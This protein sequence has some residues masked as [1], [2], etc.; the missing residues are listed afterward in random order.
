M[1]IPILENIAEAKRATVSPTRKNAA[2]LGR[3]G[4]PS[5][6]PIGGATATNPG[7]PG[8]A[9]VVDRQSFM[10][11]LIEAYLTCPPASACID[12]IARTCTAGG[13]ECAP[14]ARSTPGEK[15]PEPPPEVLEVE[16]LLHYVNPYDDIRQLMRAVITDLLIFGD[17]FTEVV[18]L[19]GKPVALYPLD[20]V[21]IAILADEH[22]VISGYQQTMQTGK[23]VTFKPWEVVHVKYDTPGSGLYGVSPLQKSILSITTWLFTAALIKE[24]MRRGDPL[25]AHVDWPIALPEAE[26]KRLQQQYAIRNIGAR[27]IGNLFETK[28]GALVKELGINQLDSWHLSLQQR[29]DEI[30]TGL[31]V[32][33]SI[34]SVIEAG[35]LGGGTGSSQHRSFQ[36][37]TCGPISEMVLEKF[38]F[39]LL[40]QAYDVKDW[41]LQF[42]LVDWRDD[43]VIEQIADLRVRSGRWTLNKSREVVGEPPVPG[44]DD[45]IIVMRQDM[46]QWSD[47]K[48]L[49]SANVDA[50]KAKAVPQ[51][52]PTTQP[53]T[54]PSSPAESVREAWAQYEERRKR[55]REELSV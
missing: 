9:G 37:N 38:S 30:L 11:S 50:I 25:R 46:A 18:Y 33:P 17:S 54:P 2:V 28:G 53:S 55:L 6:I 22:G 26:M 19:M 29:R 45:A 43:M 52:S 13:V 10:Q 42:G 49:S 47:L 5:G 40:Y 35:N 23:T 8:G 20:P 7:Q 27:N 16:E 41:H 51:G 34:V 21:T 14:N 15:P 3:R 24:T 1:G 48:E 44:G 39:A 12:V 36:I 31:G 4:Y 32:P